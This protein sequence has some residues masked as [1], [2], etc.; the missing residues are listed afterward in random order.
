MNQNTDDEMINALVKNLRNIMG[1]LKT[2]IDASFKDLYFSER[3]DG[4]FGLFYILSMLYKQ[5]LM[6]CSLKAVEDPKLFP[7]ANLWKVSA[8]LEESRALEKA[9]RKAS[10]EKALKDCELKFQ[11]F[12]YKGNNT[13]D[14]A[15]ALGLMLKTEVD[16]SK[17]YLCSFI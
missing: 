3:G 14:N 2:K 1:V 15:S 17:E 7:V 11:L 12:N 6:L 16:A 8:V 13:Y 10:S 4:L 5:L 9:L